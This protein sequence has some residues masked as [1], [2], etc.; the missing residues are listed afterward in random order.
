MEDGEALKCG[1]TKRACFASLGAA[2]VNHQ[3]AD[4][5]ASLLL[6]LVRKND[7]LKS[8]EHLPTAVAEAADFVATVMHSTSLVSQRFSRAYQRGGLNPAGAQPW[9]EYGMLVSSRRRLKL[10]QHHACFGAIFTFSTAKRGGQKLDVYV[11]PKAGTGGLHPCI[12]MSFCPVFFQQIILADVYLAFFACLFR[13]ASELFKGVYENCE[14]TEFPRV[15]RN[16]N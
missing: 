16:E 14:E 7:T 11:S 1:D 3:Q 2:A 13:A 10:A 4:A 6:T 8:F 9:L 5:V 12:C 15:K